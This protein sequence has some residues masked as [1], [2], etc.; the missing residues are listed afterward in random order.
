MTAQLTDVSQRRPLV[1]HFQNLLARRL[2]VVDFLALLRHLRNIG[3]LF[4]RR[5]RKPFLPHHLLDL[6]DRHTLRVLNY[7]FRQPFDV[8][9]DI[10]WFLT[11]VQLALL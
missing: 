4:A 10:V 7:R 5:K 6:W 3:T 9:V 11:E 8:I 1:L 2:L